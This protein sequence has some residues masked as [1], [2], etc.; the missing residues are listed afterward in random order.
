MNNERPLLTLSLGGFMNPMLNSIT[1]KVNAEI[2]S[3][4]N[5][6]HLCHEQA[7][8]DSDTAIKVLEEVFSVLASQQADTT[9][10]ENELECPVYAD[11]ICLS[12]PRT[13]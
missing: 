9:E 8:T 3:L 2:L 1:R 11:T 7:K 13:R 10:R 12:K 6:R 4:Q 5:G